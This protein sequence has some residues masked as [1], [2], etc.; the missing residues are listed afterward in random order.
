MW[1]NIQT[2]HRYLLPEFGE[3]DKGNKNA[4]KNHFIFP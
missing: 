4:N 3:Q 2:T 1:G